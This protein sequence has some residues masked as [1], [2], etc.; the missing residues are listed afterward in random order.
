ML[1]AGLAALAALP[2]AALSPSANG[3]QL[4]LET[5]MANPDWIGA[6]VE[7]PYWSVD[8]RSVY[9]ELKREGSKV[10]DL[11]RVDLASGQSSKLDPA[12][13]AQADGPAVYDRAHRRAAFVRHGDIFM[14]DLGS[15]RRVQVTRSSEPE[16]APRFSADGRSLQY[17]Q[18]NNWFVYDIAAGVSAPAAVLRFAEDPQAKQPDALSA[19]Q[20]ELF[21]S[22]RE[23]KSDKDAQRANDDALAAA[24]AGRAPKPIYLGEGAELMDTELSPDGRWMLVVTKAKDAKEGRKPEVTHFVTDSGYAERQETRTYVGRYDPAPQS[25]TLVDLKAAKC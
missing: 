9:Y 13:V 24:D 17:R 18:G 6:A 1:F 19:Q 2:A 12:A 16:S 25:L 21:R 23:N 3:A 10:R 8:G 22:L 5:I 15:G 11:Y 4:D 7:S 20:L 14:V